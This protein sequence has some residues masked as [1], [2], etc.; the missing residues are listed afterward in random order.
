MWNYQ[1]SQY[2]SKLVDA[3]I[4]SDL[5]F[6]KNSFEHEKNKELL[7]GA[8][9]SFVPPRQLSRNSKEFIPCKDLTL[10]HIAAY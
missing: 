9:Y 7:K 8:S 6:L 10:L 2:F 3:T 1:T 4:D 5:A